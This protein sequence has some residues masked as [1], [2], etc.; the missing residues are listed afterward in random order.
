M[1]GGLLGRRTM[2]RNTIR[3]VHGVNSITFVVLEEERN[4]FRAICRGRVTGISV[5]RLGR[6]VAVEIGKVLR[7]RRET[8]R[9]ERLHVHRVSVLSAPTRPLPVTVSG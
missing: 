4:L 1:N 6:T 7:R 5:R 9:K 2:V 8:P 3:D